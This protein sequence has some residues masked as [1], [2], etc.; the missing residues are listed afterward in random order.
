MAY[1]GSATTGTGMASLMPIFYEKV[2]LERLLAELVLY[3]LATKKA[4]PRSSGKTVYFHR[5]FNMSTTVSAHALTEGTAPTQ[6]LTSAT[7]V[8]ATLIQYGHNVS[9][10]DLLEMTAV[11]DVVKYA[12]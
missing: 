12:M 6:G 5:Y 9:T 4:V 8:S 11:S 3:K 1:T 10:S 7:V 2:A